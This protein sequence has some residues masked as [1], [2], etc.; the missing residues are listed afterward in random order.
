VTGFGAPIRPTRRRLCAAMG[1]SAFFIAVILALF[2]SLVDFAGRVSI[3]D[4]EHAG[5]L[6]VVIRTDDRE[7]DSE[8]ATEKKSAPSPS[9][10]AVDPADP[11]DSQRKV[12][13]PLAPVPPVDPQPVRDW[14]AFAKTAARASVD[15]FFRNEKS[16]ASM[17][18]QTRS[19]MFKPA[20]DFVVREEEPAIP[21]FRFKPEIHVVGLGLTIGSC[22]IGIPIAGVPSRATYS[23]Y[24]YFCVRQRLKAGRRLPAMNGL[25]ESSPSCGSGPSVSRGKR[26]GSGER[27]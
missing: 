15:D 19:I 26:A 21:D 7:P 20:S 4:L 10:Q 6:T 18:R 2:G 8:F 16:R 25:S 14:H 23:G 9:P 27:R 11:I 17:W 12:S 5:R 22:F 24:K 13:A 3:T 1:I